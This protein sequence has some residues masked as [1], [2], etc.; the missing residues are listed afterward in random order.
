MYQY[1]LSWFLALFEASIKGAEKSSQLAKRT[2]ALVNHFQYSLYVQVCR[3]VKRECRPS[4]AQYYLQPICLVSADPVTAQH[5]SFSPHT[6]IISPPI[7]SLFEKDKTLFS[8]LMAVHL[9]AHIQCNLDMGLFRFLLTGEH[10]AESGA[11]DSPVGVLRDATVY[12]LHKTVRTITEQSYIRSA[13]GV[14][15]SDPPENPSTWLSDKLW[16]ELCRL[17]SAGG[18]FLGLAED[19]A[20]RQADFKVRLSTWVGWRVA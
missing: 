10:N 12:I 19:F 2:D 5:P 1:S 9:R 7:R 18:P 11:I 8:F 6:C 15:S 16:G 4:Q 17:N 14:A 3:C 20:A 13:G